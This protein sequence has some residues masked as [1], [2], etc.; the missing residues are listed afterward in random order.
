MR[1]VR[2]LMDCVGFVSDQ[3]NLEMK[4]KDGLMT[5]QT[6]AG[7]QV[8]I[9]DEDLSVLQDNLYIAEQS[10]VIPSGIY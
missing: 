7:V 2:V 5:L 10:F 3:P 8:P 6:S 1:R 4:W 9:S